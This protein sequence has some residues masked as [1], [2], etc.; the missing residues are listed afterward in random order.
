M[1]AAIASYTI[2]NLKMTLGVPNGFQLQN[3]VENIG[4]KNLKITTLHI[5]VKML[6][7]TMQTSTEKDGTTCHHIWRVGLTFAMSY[8]W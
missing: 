5:S 6:L 3:Y 8:W 1:D 4:N 7:G 2:H